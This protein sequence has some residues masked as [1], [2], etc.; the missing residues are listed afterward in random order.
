VESIQI[1][2]F[3]IV[4]LIPL[5]SLLMRRRAKA[6]LFLLVAQILVYLLYETGVSVD[7]NIRFDIPLVVIAIIWNLIIVARPGAPNE[8]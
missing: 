7:T 3:L 5:L 6:L 2:L 1:P 8:Q 4:M